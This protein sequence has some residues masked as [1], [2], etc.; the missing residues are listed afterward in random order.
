MT[1]AL[2]FL[3]D[4]KLGQYV[5]L[6]PR[7]TFCMQAAGKDVRTL[8]LGKELN[9]NPIGSIVGALLNCQSFSI[10]KLGIEYHCVMLM[11]YHFPA[12]AVTITI[13]NSQRDGALQNGVSGLVC[14]LRKF[15]QR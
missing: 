12:D 6:A 2:N 11:L 5:K 9:T 13:L 14:I 8:V 4:L 1:Q 10:T 3:Q 15:A 7:V